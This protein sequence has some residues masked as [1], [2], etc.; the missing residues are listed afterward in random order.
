MPPGTRTR[1]HALCSRAMV[2]SDPQELAI[3]L[4]EIDSILS[5]TLSEL[6]AMLKDVERLLKK[7]EQ[8]SRIHLA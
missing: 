2:E 1:L 4:N 3:L 8:T 5:E 7:R 6:S